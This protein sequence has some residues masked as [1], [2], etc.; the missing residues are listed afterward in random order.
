LLLRLAFECEA[1]TE[2]AVFFE[3]ETV[4][5]FELTVEEAEEE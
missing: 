1:L 3:A 5:F 2:V 4:A